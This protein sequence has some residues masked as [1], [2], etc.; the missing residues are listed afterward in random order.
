M[1]TKE[2]NCAPIEPKI[3]NILQSNLFP[4]PTADIFI[5]LVEVAK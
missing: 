2:Q 5:V 4:S 1:K 3:F